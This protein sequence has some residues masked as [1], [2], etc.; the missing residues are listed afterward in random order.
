MN[1]QQTIRKRYGIDVEV[2]I[3]VALRSDPRKTG[4]IESFGQY[5]NTICVLWDNDN[6]PEYWHSFAA[7]CYFVDGRWFVPPS[8]KVTIPA[9]PARTYEII[10]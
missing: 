2:G 5:F 10:L 8:K 7:L 9:Q 4:V 6:R 3:R 1:T